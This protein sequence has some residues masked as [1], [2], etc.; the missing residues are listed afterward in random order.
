MRRRCTERLTRDGTTVEVEVIEGDPVQMLSALSLLRRV[1]PE[2]PALI[3]F[4]VRRGQTDEFDTLEQ[5]LAGPDGTRLREQLEASWQLGLIQ[6][7]PEDVIAL[8]C[9]LLAGC[10]VGGRE[11]PH[12][13]KGARAVLVDALSWR[14][15]V[16]LAWR[17]IAQCY[18]PILA[19]DATSGSTPAG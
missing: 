11:V 13:A 18:V 3:M 8:V 9:Q 10:K 19:G 5:A 4:G 7:D 12:D 17:Q 16:R 2:V 1:A 15:L 14:G 6:S